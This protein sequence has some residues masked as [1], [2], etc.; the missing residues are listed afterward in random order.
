M[1]RNQFSDI[2]RLLRFNTKSNRLERLQTETFGLFSE[3]WNRFIDNYYTIHRPETFITV[4]KQL[5]S[6]KVRC[7]FTQFMPSK[8]KTF[9]Q[10]YWLAIENESKYLINSIS[11]IGKVKTFIL[12]L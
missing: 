8:L 3:V 12:L 4:D 1:S 7:I 2:L 5:F 11:Y 10:K 9:R 6:S